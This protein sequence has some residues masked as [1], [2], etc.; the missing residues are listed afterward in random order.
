MLFEFRW[1]THFWRGLENFGDDCASVQ[2]LPA[3]A[4]LANSTTLTQKSSSTQ[5][6]ATSEPVSVASPPVVMRKEQQH[7]RQSV[8]GLAHLLAT[9][10]AARE[11]PRHH[12]HASAKPRR[13][14]GGAEPATRRYSGADGSSSISGS[15]PREGSPAR[16]SKAA[17]DG[18]T[19]T[20]RGLDTTEFDCA[21][22]LA[23]RSGAE[24]AICY[25][26]R[27]L[28]TSLWQS[29]SVV[30]PGKHDARVTR[31]IFLGCD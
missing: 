6:R 16:G 29:I 1:P 17:N 13:R 4:S 12:G 27:A 24:L 10:A 19:V 2:H 31:H 28:E 25:E 7:R 26:R 30:G 22:L 20:L 5:S 8:T 15:A 23:A 11:G 18:G 14:H 9:A 21:M 3:T